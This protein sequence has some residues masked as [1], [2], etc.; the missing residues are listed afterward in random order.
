M[1]AYL[2]KYHELIY[3]PD[4]RAKNLRQELLLIRDKKENFNTG[5]KENVIADCVDTEP[6]I[7]KEFFD[8]SMKSQTTLTYASQGVQIIDPKIL[9]IPEKKIV[10]HLFGRRQY[11]YTYRARFSRSAQ[12]IHFGMLIKTISGSN[13]LLLDEIVLR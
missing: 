10:N 8:S 11:Y 13:W 7:S 3:A 5:Q 2:S 1:I 9:T 4:E 12:N 6:V